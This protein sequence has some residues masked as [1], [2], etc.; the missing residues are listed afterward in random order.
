MNPL[1]AYKSVYL[2]KLFDKPE[3]HLIVGASGVGKT[4]FVTKLIRKY[5]HKFTHIIVSGTFKSD[6]EKYPETSCKLQVC[7]EGIYNPF[8]HFEIAD[9]VPLQKRHVLLLYDD[10]MDVFL[11]SK[12]GADIFFKGRHWG[13][14]VIV[15]LQNFYQ[16]G[17][18]SQ[19]IRGQCTHLTL[20]KIRN[21][22]QI[23][24]LGRNIEG[25]KNRVDK[26]IEIYDKYVKKKP[27]GYVSIFLDDPDE[28]RYRTHLVGEKGAYDTV[29]KFDS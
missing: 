26:F 11:N 8:T 2:G 6:L 19:T 23:L 24:T 4:D 7:R 9:K 5:S 16:K 28:T 21:L 14:S 27:F 18:Y 12:I 22:Q 10:A 29:I 20:F 13:L 17:S 15:T 1:D 25:T 3:R